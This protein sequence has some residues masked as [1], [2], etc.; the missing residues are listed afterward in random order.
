[1]KIR[2]PYIVIDLINKVKQLLLILLF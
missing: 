2:T 1:M